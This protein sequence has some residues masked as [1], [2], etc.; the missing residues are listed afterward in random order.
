MLLAHVMAVDVSS[1]VPTQPEAEY[2]YGYGWVASGGTV[3]V[4]HR[5]KQRRREGEAAGEEAAGQLPWVA[6]P[7]QE[8]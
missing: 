5:T 8:A 4:I 6:Q 3:A 2:A 1:I 7:A